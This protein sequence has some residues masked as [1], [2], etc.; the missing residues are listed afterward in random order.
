[1]EGD[2]DSVVGRVT[3]TLVD[4]GWDVHTSER[5][6]GAAAGVAPTHVVMAARDGVVVRVVVAILGTV[7]APAGAQWT[8]LGVAHPDERLGW[9][10]TT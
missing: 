4:G 9:T 2:L 6:D 7:P 3:A 10:I 8:Q 5:H 1:M